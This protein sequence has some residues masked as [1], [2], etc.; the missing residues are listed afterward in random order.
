MTSRK[1][2]TTLRVAARRPAAPERRAASAARRGFTLVELL[3]VMA[4]MVTVSAILVAN[5]FGMTRAA[6]YT[7]AG[8]NVYNMLMLARQRACMDGAPVHFMLIDSNSYVLVRGAGTLCRNLENNLIRDYY[9][10]LDA[11]AVDLD[12]YSDDE[13]RVWNMDNGACAV[14]DTHGENGGIRKWTDEKATFPDSNA[15]YKRVSYTIKLR[16]ANAAE[17]KEGHRYGFELYPRQLL[18]KGFRF[19]FNSPQQTPRNEVIA[20]NPDGSTDLNSEA[21]IYIY[22]TIKKGDSKDMLRI[23]VEPNGTIVGPEES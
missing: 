19:G 17:W 16:S 23:T 20:F 14:V 8:R 2:T 5:Y 7:A 10:D 6:S 12:E 21:R 1:K 13:I 22:E 4:I 11:M 18:P 9:A 15:T 3:V